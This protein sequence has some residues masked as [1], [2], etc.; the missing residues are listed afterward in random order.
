MHSYYVLNR[1]RA[2]R[3]HFGLARRAHFGLG[4]CPHVVGFVLQALAAWRWF[5]Y[6]SGQVPPGKEPLRLNLD[7]TSICLFQGSGRGN[8][9]ISK[10]R[11]LRQR[12]SRATRRRCLTHVAVI[13]DQ[14]EVQPLL[15]QVILGNE[16]TFQARR[17]ATLRA[18][19]P[20]NVVLLRGK[21]A[22]NNHVV[23]AWI[24]GLIG[25]ALAPLRDRYQPILLLDASRI[26]FAPQVLAACRRWRIWVVGVPAQLT[27]LLQP[28]DTHG[29]QRYKAHLRQKYLEARIVA[30]GD[31]LDIG[32]F[33]P[34]V[35]SAVRSVLQG[36]RWR[37]AFDQDGFGAQQEMVAVRVLHHMQHEGRLEVPSTRPAPAEVARCFPRR[38]RVPA[39]L[40]RPFDAAAPPIVPVAVPSVAALGPRALL[41]P[42]AI[43]PVA[44]AAPSSSSSSR[45]PVAA[46]V[47]IEGREPRT[48]AEHRR[49]AAAA[50]GAASVGPASAAS[51]APRAIPLSDIPTL[52]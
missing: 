36:I 31:A 49:A 28:L 25:H 4:F 42:L 52:D 30:V 3:A 13:C 7:E 8:V 46:P 41:R 50:A 51:S 38:A 35:Y 20:G 19:C 24:I 16:A 43:A 17:M 44:A 32:E 37:G 34:C 15:P 11:V 45:A 18:A 14:T 33:M 40:W 9:F 22:W 10:K 26:H 2:R 23:C 12:V 29:F 5:N 21:S 47:V 48:R 1:G 27:W 6:V 39:S